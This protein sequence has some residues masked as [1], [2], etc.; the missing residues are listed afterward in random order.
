M[1]IKSNLRCNVTYLK[2]K[3][4]SLTIMII[5]KAIIFKIQQVVL[6]I[7]YIIIIVQANRNKKEIKPNSLTIFIKIKEIER[8]KWKQ[9][10]ERILVDW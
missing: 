6:I 3:I 1:I 10:D 4:L 9:E 2:R 5:S 8:L 7:S